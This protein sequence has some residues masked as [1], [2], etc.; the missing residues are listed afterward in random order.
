MRILLFGDTGS[1]SRLLNHMPSQN[2]VGI[3]GADIRPQYHDKLRSL[4]DERGIPCLFQP[5]AKDLNYPSFVK[6]VASIA[7]DLIWVNSYSMLL[8]EEILRIP[9]CGGLNIHGALLPQYR[10]CNPTQWAILNN[11]HKTGVTLHEMSEDIDQGAIIAQKTVPLYFEDT[12]KSV[13]ARISVATGQMIDENLTSI[14][15]GHWQAIAQ[16]DSKAQ[17]HRRRTLNDGEFSWNQP[18]VEIYNLIRALVAPHPG[19]FFVDE[20]GVRVV[21]DEYVTPAEIVALK[22][23]HI[24]DG[25]ILGKQIR[26]RPQRREDSDLLY[27]WITQRELFIQNAP[28]QP[29][30]EIDHKDW[31]DSML[32]KQTDLVLFVIEEIEPGCVIGICQL[33]NINWLH[34]SAEL[35][36]RISEIDAQSRGLRSEA[37]RLLCDFGFKEL[38]LHRIYLHVFGS[39]ERTVRAYEKT[40]FQRE[41]VS[42]EAAHIDGEFVDVLSMGLLKVKDE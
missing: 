37:V 25:N 28:F 22:Y 18:V 6:Q 3:V 33:M 8:R 41:G 31:F 5:E 16:D 11:E 20:K 23:P 21:F 4:A 14:L 30:R 27:E 32:V 29:V 39:N 19:A 9:Q 26:L 35:Q 10:G 12:W 34:R 36:I 24:G 15:T 40:G 38:N 7:P 42:R 2:V 13:Q 1:V 17:Y